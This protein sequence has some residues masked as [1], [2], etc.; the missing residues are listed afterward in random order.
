MSYIT[1][2]LKEEFFSL[3]LE[4]ACSILNVI[5]WQDCYSISS[6]LLVAKSPEVKVGQLKKHIKY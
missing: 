4:E 1:R 5:L 6:L 2:K 3:I